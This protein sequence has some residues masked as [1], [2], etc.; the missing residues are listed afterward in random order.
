MDVRSQGEGWME[1]KQKGKP[2]NANI[3]QRTEG[4]TKDKDKPSGIE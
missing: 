2:I 3:G 1:R 4:L